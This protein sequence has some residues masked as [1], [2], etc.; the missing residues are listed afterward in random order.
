MAHQAA[1]IL[2][3]IAAPL[4]FAIGAIAYGTK[5][6]QAG[7]AE[8]RGRLVAARQP[9]S[10]ARYDAR[11]IAELP[12]PVQRYFQAVLRDG[13]PLI[14]TAK[15]SQSGKFNLGETQARWR[16]FTASQLTITRR[17]G[18]DWNAR[19]AM[20]PGMNVFV[21]DAYA[22]GTGSLHAALF[23]VVRL[24][25]QRGTEAAAQGELMRFL[26]EAVWYPT[27]LLPSQGVR[28]TALDGAAAR[29]M[30]TDGATT[31]ALDFH[32]DADGL[33][34]GV[35][36]P[37]RPRMVAGALVATPWRGSF[38]DYET[39]DDMRIP[40]TG[41]ASWLLPDGPQPY[42]RGRI[43]GIAYDFAP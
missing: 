15:L 4:L 16:P 22:D 32:F 17:P 35:S 9:L 23:G 10:P 28:W 33:V 25:E 13:Q 26:A 40:T 43:D 24:A 21:H 7:T 5:R 36:T 3:V 37:S 31:V 18:F 27:A 1:L 34:T 12:P 30:L 6:W 41:E 19:I 42:W 38:L 8:L 20:A 29:A 39:R 11:E 14:A 2:F